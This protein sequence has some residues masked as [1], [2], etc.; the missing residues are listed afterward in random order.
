MITQLEQR[1][2]VPTKPQLYEYVEVE[3][4]CGPHFQG[5]CLRVR[6]GPGESYPVIAGLRTGIVLKV[7]DTV[8]GEGRVWYKILFN[9]GLRFSER[10]AGNWYVSADYVRLFMDE[11]ILNL[12]NNENASST[13]R[14][15]IDRSQQMLYAYDGATLFLEV[16]IST[17]LELNPTPR[18]TFT[19][20]RKTPSRYM[21]GPIPDV[22]DDYF[23]LPGVPWN[24]Y[25]TSEGAVIHGAYW[26]DKFG[27]PWSHGCV[28]LPPE[29]AQ[30]LYQWAD[31]G[32]KVLV[33]D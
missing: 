23:D 20:Y 26:H 1:E 10:V 6:S 3:D 28:N 27:Q 13:K 2:V 31:I 24:L 33:Q 15:F 11:G 29:Q 9:E 14:I 21:Q 30:K 8:I 22:S 5:E 4:G 7:A 17:G 12:S 25:F 32:T 19:V 18:G 16:L